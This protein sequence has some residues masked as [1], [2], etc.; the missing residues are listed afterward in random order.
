MD[1]D[2]FL[3]RLVLL[4]VPLSLVSFGG[5]SSILAGIERGAVGQ[6]GWFDHDE[7][8]SLF[9]VS[10]ASPGPGTMLATL[11]GWRLQG[12]PGAVVAT[13]AVYLPSSVL[14]YGIHRMTA[15]GRDRRWF[16]I[17]RTGLA[18]IGTGL[19]IAGVVNIVRISGAGPLGLAMSTGSFAVLLV[20]PGL[21]L[22]LLLLGGAVVALML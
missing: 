10:R 5:G 6:F 22:P 13:L 9:A 18:P 11:I 15:R 2:D 7:F 3:L 4:L 1:D 16:R 17:L 21:P 12:W 19:I 20:W 8:L 14:C